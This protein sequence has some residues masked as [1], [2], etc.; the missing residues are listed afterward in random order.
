[1][2]TVPCLPIII[3]TVGALTAIIMGTARAAAGLPVRAAQAVRAV[4]AEGRTEAFF[5]C[6]V[7]AAL[8]RWRW[9]G[10][11]VKLADDAVR[12]SRGEAGRIVA[13][14]SCFADF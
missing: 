4:A 6:E 8:V 11:A 7:P 3:M 2:I 12:T 5:C 1:M 10:P 9:P 14:R 13:F